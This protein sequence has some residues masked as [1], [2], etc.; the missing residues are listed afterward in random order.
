ML[1]VQSPL[2]QNLER[3][4]HRTIGCCIEV[5]RQLGPGLLEQIYQRA[6]ELELSAAGIPFERQKSFPVTYR[7]RHIYVHRVDL[8]VHDCLVLEL[9]AVERIHPVHEAQT[10]SSLR[11]SKLRVALLINFNVAILPHGIKRKVL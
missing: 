9:K 2:D 3:L 7:G 11:V 10:L 6:V 1:R 8:V 5:H 4:I